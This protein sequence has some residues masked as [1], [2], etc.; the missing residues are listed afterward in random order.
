MVSRNERKGDAKPATKKNVANA[1]VLGE[2]S[3]KK[4]N[5]F[6][7]TNPKETQSP[8]RKKRSERCGS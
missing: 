2:R 6:L 7:A 8:Q 5:S 3:E 1:A 4:K